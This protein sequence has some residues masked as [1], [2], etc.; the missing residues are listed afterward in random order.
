MLL[1]PEVLAEG[2]EP[3]ID[4][5]QNIPAG[6]LPWWTERI[7][8][9]QPIVLNSLDEL[10]EK[11]SAEYD[12]LSKQN[13]KSLLVVPLNWNSRTITQNTHMNISYRHVAE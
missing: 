8:L 12:I 1:I 13:I 11:A 4:I 9:G 10:K 6:S 2:V 3:E 5:L 7:L